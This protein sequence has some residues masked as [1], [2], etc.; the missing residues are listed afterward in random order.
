[1]D[2]LGFVLFGWIRHTVKSIPLI[3]SPNLLAFDY[4][5]VILSPRNPSFFAV[6]CTLSL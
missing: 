6:E 5:I 1:M 2:N 4:A 3:L